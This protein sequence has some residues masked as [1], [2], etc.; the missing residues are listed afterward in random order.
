M[1]NTTTDMMDSL[2]IKDKLQIKNG[3]LALANGLKANG[4]GV[5]TISN[6]APAGLTATI[7]GW[8]EITV[9]GTVCYI[10]CWSA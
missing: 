1:A 6:L 2:V 5:V 9:Q 8:V 10:P 7:A 4:A 3:K